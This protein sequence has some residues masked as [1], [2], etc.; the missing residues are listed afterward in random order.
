M[1]STVELSR[2]T[3]FFSDLAGIP[4]LPESLQCLHS[5]Q[6]PRVLDLLR[7]LWGRNRALEAIRQKRSDSLV[8]V[9]ADLRQ[10]RMWIEFGGGASF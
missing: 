6:D 8:L 10:M 4:H 3:S 5:R 1:Q 9:L 7:S 2:S